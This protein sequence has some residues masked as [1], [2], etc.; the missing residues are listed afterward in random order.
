MVRDEG[1][2]NGQTQTSRRK[3]FLAFY[4]SLEILEQF[5]GGRVDDNVG[6]CF[7]FRTRCLGNG[8]TELAVL[9]GDRSQ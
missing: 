3:R 1:H 4:G 5:P 8:R 6:V 2:I 7:E 9:M